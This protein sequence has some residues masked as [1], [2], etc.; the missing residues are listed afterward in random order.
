MSG[1][2]FHYEFSQGLYEGKDLPLSATKMVTYSIV[3]ER[4]EHFNGYG[5][6]VA[7]HVVRLSDSP[8]IFD[9]GSERNYRLPFI[10]PEDLFGA[11]LEFYG[12]VERMIRQ[13]R[14]CKDIYGRHVDAELPD[15]FEEVRRRNLQED[16]WKRYNKWCIVS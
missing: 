7:D 12:K 14:E 8:F 3:K 6:Y 13:E 10:S 4:R 11:E 9:S 1:L 5:K 16:L 15:N 2:E